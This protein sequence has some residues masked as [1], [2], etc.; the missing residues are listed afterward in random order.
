M[1]YDFLFHISWEAGN[2][3]DN[4]ISATLLIWHLELS[5]TSTYPVSDVCRNFDGVLCEY[6]CWNIG[7]LTEFIVHLSH[8]DVRNKKLILIHFCSSIHYKI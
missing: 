6:N 4:L 1:S 8:A 2:N 5:F 7:Q 3:F